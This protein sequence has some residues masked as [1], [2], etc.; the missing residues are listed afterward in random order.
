MKTPISPMA[1]NLGG[2]C[3]TFTA[4]AGIDDTHVVGD[5]L[6]G[7][8]AVSDA[9]AYISEELDA[10]EYDKVSISLKD[11]QYLGLLMAYVGTVGD[12]GEALA[13]FGD[14]KILCSQKPAA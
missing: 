3:L 13:G 14:P 2:K 8:L 9:D 10:S 5:P 11:S 1:G 6:A 4:T 7:F 12:G